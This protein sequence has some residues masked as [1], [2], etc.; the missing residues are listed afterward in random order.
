MRK[1]FALLLAAMMILASVSAIA[2]SS[3]TTPTKVA[4]KEDEE[5]FTQVDLGKV[6]N[7][8]KDNM[9]TA[10]DNGSSPLD[11]F[12]PETVQTI[13]EKIGTDKAE[14]HEMFGLQFTGWTEEDGEQYLILEFATEYK[15]GTPVTAVLGLVHGEE[16]PVEYVLDAK[17]PEDYKVE[18]YF[19]VA[20]LNELLT[21][22]EIFVV[23]V[24]AAE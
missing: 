3:P 12:K 5:F 4:Q 8:Y 19:P 16:E 11:V 20:M 14:V 2:E 7:E 9:Q 6:G 24:N 13:I 17:V 22:D 23:I 18:V 21:A 1:L 10:I 15:E